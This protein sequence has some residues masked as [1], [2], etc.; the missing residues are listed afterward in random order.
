[1]TRRDGVNPSNAEATF[2]QTPKTQRFLKNLLSLFGIGQ[3]SHQQYKSY[4]VCPTIPSPT[5][6][7]SGV[8]A[9]FDTVRSNTLIIVQFENDSKMFVFFS[10]Q[11]IECE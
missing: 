4:G 1:M 7:M 10:K 11:R 2:V 3:I 6:V 9:C 5:Q 8:S